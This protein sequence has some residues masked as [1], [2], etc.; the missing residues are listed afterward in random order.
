[1][2][3]PN[4]Y[5]AELRIGKHCVHRASNPV[6]LVNGKWQYKVEMRDVILMARSGTWAMVRRPRCAPYVCLIRELQ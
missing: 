3:G 1:M 6:N 4:S 2:I 5:G